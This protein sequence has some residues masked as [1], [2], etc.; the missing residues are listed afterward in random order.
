MNYI[1]T[2]LNPVI[3]YTLNPIYRQ[4]FNELLNRPWSC[5]FRCRNV[6]LANAPVNMYTHSKVE[7]QSEMVNRESETQAV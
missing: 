6:T 2:A 5:F 7:Q 3:Y 4:G 1:Y